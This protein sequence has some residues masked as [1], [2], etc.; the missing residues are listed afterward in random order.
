MNSNFNHNQQN[1][2]KITPSENSCKKPDFKKI[3][4]NTFQTLMVI[5]MPIA[6]YVIILV[7][8]NANLLFPWQIEARVNRKAILEYAAENHPTAKKTKEVYK[9]LNWNIFKSSSVD[10]I[11]FDQDGVLFYVSAEGGEIF[12]DSYNGMRLIAEFD[13]IIQD[14]FM[15]PNGI[16][17]KTTYT[18]VDSSDMYPYTG[19]LGVTIRIFDQGSTPEE[20]GCLYDFYNYWQSEADFLR[21]YLVHIYIVENQG[22]TYHG[23]FVKESNYTSE[24]EFYADFRREE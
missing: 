15:N 24:A 23:A 17:A 14:G 13:A 22:T 16:I 4:K 7:I 20:I 12:F 9:S 21:D 1:E 6:I 10:Y 2:P 18:F 11:Q 3:D 19:D 5:F 8:L